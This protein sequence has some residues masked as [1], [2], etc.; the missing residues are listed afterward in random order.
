MRGQERRA[1]ERR[2]Q[3]RSRRVPRAGLLAEREGALSLRAE[4]AGRSEAVRVRGLFSR[5]FKRVT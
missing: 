5:S 3:V 2:E 1:H 4:A